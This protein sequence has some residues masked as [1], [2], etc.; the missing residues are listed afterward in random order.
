MNDYIYGLT[1]DD[2]GY[3]YL[4]GLT[5]SPDFPVNFTHIQDASSDN[6]LLM[7]ID[8][9]TGN[10]V[11]SATIGGSSSDFSWR[12]KT[13]LNGNVLVLGQTTSSDF[14][15]INASGSFEGSVSS[16][17]VKFTPNG[18]ILWSKVFGG[19]GVDISRELVINSKNEYYLA[20]YTTSQDFTGNTSEHK[21]LEDIFVLKMTNTGEMIWNR[22]FGGNKTDIGRSIFLDNDEN[23]IVAGFSYSFDYPTKDSPFGKAHGR[24]DKVVMKLTPKGEI[25]WS[26]LY[27]TDGNDHACGVVVDKLGNIITLGITTSENATMNLGFDNTFNGGFW[28]L[29]I[30]IFNSTGNFLKSTYLGGEGDEIGGNIA[31]ST[32][33]RIA[34]TGFT[35]SEDFPQTVHSHNLTNTGSNAYVA[36]LSNITTYPE[37]ETNF[38][39]TST[40]TTNT[41]TQ[42]HQSSIGPSPDT[43]TTSKTVSNTTTTTDFY[44]FSFVSLAIFLFSRKKDKYR[45]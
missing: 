16:F 37:P 3:L 35:N 21:G 36:V 31:I 9:E 14:P 6:C 39:G 40:T 2:N 1:I 20:G 4:S 25:I 29:E 15:L 11:W 8:A 5:A 34:I 22:T 45:P 7:K 17:L 43:Q 28:D 10:V 32:T 33:N 18:S 23:I 41:Q 13:D 26:I 38:T 27:G 12:V 19:S 44:V 24:T 30:V 42:S